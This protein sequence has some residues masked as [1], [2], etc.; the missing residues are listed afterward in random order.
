MGN[1]K[2]FTLIELM[3]VVAIIG[4]LAAIAIPMYTANMNKARLQ[5]ATDAIGAIKDEVCNYASDFG[6]PP[7]TLGGQAQILSTLGVQVPLSRGGTLAA[8]GGYKWTYSTTDNTGGGA[9]NGTYVIRA[10]GGATADIGSVLSG[11]TV[12]IQGNW[13]ANQGVFTDWQWGSTGNISQ[14]WLP[15]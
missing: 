13:I 3:I 15:K 10:V 9:A 5:E 1:K 11:Q 12:R 6:A 7:G 8:P 14:S 4:I 2:G